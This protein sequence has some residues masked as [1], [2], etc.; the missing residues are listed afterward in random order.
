ME[1]DAV[2]RLLGSQQFS[3]TPKSVPNLGACFVGRVGSGVMATS[4]GHFTGTVAEPSDVILDVFQTSELRQNFGETPVV[5]T[6]VS[7][8]RFGDGLGKLERREEFS[9]ILGRVDQ[10]LK[11]A[12]SG[13]HIPCADLAKDDIALGNPPI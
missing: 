12:F 1:P 4:F 10:A 2:H 9:L 8:R 13:R 3:L 11:D 6:P 5:T 7:L